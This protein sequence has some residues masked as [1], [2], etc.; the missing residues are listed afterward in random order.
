MNKYHDGVMIPECLEGMNIEPSG[1]YVDVTFGG[2]GH[3]RAIL[4]Q[5]DNGKLFAFDQDEDAAANILEDGRFTLIR[6]NFRY[7][8]N[9]LRFY[10]I[11]PVD[12]LL[13]DLGVSSHQFDADTRGFSIRFDGPLDMRMNQSDDL[14]AEKVI[15]EYDEEALTRI[16]RHYG[17]LKSPGK[18]AG[19]IVRKRED[20]HIKTTEALKAALM[21]V[22][23]KGKDFK[24][25]AKIFQAIRIEVNQELEA[26]R[27]LLEQCGD[28]IKKKGRIAFITYHSLEDRMV[29]N[30]IRSGNVE[31]Q[32]EK[33]FYGNVLRPFK[34]V[35]RKPIVP[36]EEEI[37]RNNRARSAKLRVAERI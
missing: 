9:Y 30:Y 5:L 26:L 16:F 3:S 25:F 37:N 1:T 31:G 36:S 18:I 7:A 29:K 28:L 10:N 2:G 11:L 4:E 14:N 23:P 15:N 32:I 24:F 13:A 19:T 33:D 20:G 35:N 34:A 27:Q 22:A 17:E 6:Q 21:E 8:T 12:A